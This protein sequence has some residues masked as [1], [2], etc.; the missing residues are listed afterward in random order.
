MTQPKV[1]DELERLLLPLAQFFTTHAGGGVYVACSGGRDSLSLAHAC[2]LLYQQGRIRHLPTLV[3][4]HHGIQPANAEWAAQVASWAHTHEFNCHIL[5]LDLGRTNETDARTARYAAFARLMSEGDVLLTAH[6]RDDQAETVIMRL[7]AGTGIHGLAGIKPW[8]TKVIDDTSICIHR[9]WLSISRADITAYARTHH[10]PYID[11][12]TNN[13]TDNARNLIRNIVLPHLHTINPQASAN[14]ARSAELLSQSVATLDDMIAQG[15]SACLVH[16]SPY[17]SI[18]AIDVLLTLPHQQ[19]TSIL[20]RFVQGD[21]P[22]PPTSRITHELMTLVLR[23]DNNHHSRLFWQNY[24]FCR[25]GDRLYRYHKLAFELLKNENNQAVSIHDDGYLLKS[26]AMFVLYWQPPVGVGTLRPKPLNRH[27]K[28][29]VILHTGN[30]VQLHGKKLAQTLKIP[31]WLRHNL[32]V[33]YDDN[34]PIALISIA[35]VWWLTHHDDTPAITAATW[36]MIK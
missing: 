10:L 24:L 28:L 3:H 32:W 16:H 7:V 36:Q 14:I 12:P 34:T 15:L 23:S 8:Q 2:Y 27:D 4:I 31:P 6:H 9:P 25:Y 21:M 11:D 18:L 5:R 17:D 30:T 33:I 19:H 13:S 22:N 26:D 1:D 20:H 35:H 29:P